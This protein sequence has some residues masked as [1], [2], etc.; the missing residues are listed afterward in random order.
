MSFEFLDNELVAVLARG[1]WLVGV[2][3]GGDSVALLK[4][5]MEA[6]LREQIVVGNFDHGWGRFGKESHAFVAKLAAGLDLRFL[7]GEGGGKAAGNAEEVAREERYGWFREVC[8]AEGMDGVIVAHTADDM[9]ETFL[10]RLGKGSGLQG[11][12]GMEA[13]AVVNGV[14]VV[15]P[16]LAAGREELR[17]YL[18]G[19]GQEWMEDPDNVAGGS[20]RA[21]VRGLLPQLEGVGVTAQGILA[22]MKALRDANNAVEGL[23]AVSMEAVEWRPDGEGATVGLEVL[24]GIQDEVGV[25]LLAGL[26]VRM[27][28]KMGVVRRSKR[29]ALLARLRA[30]EQGFATLGGLK[31][32]WKDGVVRVEREHAND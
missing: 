10:M 31:F 22:S 27:V 15:R 8:E 9:V 19:M 3:G 6:G 13:D 2:S 16:L 5:L 11:L 4:L 24:R 23:V 28:P 21:R 25:R 30:D 14:R 32:S 17:A 26:M 12:V 20:Q 18:R 29:M 1:R 7:G